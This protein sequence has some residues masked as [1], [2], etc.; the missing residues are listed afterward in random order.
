MVD[1][2]GSEYATRHADDIVSGK[3]RAR[4]VL[5]WRNAAVAIYLLHETVEAIE[6]IAARQPIS[7]KSSHHDF[8]PAHG[9]TRPVG[10]RLEELRSTV[11]FEGS[12]EYPKRDMCSGCSKRT[13]LRCV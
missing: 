8:V 6:H 11:L 5:A 9:S 12:E 1:R 4:S 7:A 10:A 2:A 3:E 13:R